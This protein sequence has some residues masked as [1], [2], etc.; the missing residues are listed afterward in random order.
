MFLVV[1]A[2]STLNDPIN[3]ENFKWNHKNTT[4]FLNE[5]R[6][7]IN[8]FKDP[9]IKKKHIWESIANKMKEQGFNVTGGML[10]RKLRNMK[11][12]YRVILDSKHKNP[13][14]GNVHWKYFDVFHEVFQLIEGDLYVPNIVYSD[15]VIIKNVSQDEPMDEEGWETVLCTFPNL[16]QT[17]STSNS[18][19]W[20][21][22]T[23]IV[24]LEKYKARHEQFIDPN[25]KKKDI[26][27]I[28]ASEMRELGYD[29]NW[30]VIDRKF[31]N[32]KVT[33]RNVLE[34]CTK[35]NMGLDRIKWEYFYAF[36]DIFQNESTDDTMNNCVLD[37]VHN[38]LPPIM[39]Q[40]PNNFVWN[41]KSTILFLEEFKKRVDQFSDPIYRKKDIWESITQEMQ[42][43]GYNVNADMLDRKLRNMKVTFRT[44][45]EKD[46]GKKGKKWRYF[47]I[48]QE[49]FQNDRKKIMARRAD[50]TRKLLLIEEMKL[51]E[52][53]KL[54]EAIEESNRISLERIKI[55]KENLMCM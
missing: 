4:T 11:A 12:T 39:E 3:I 22:E 32:M 24:L 46:N 26:W 2:D 6:E 42:S 53:R 23:T 14:K 31:R 48:F 41:H 30:E 40:A 55:L 1:K 17:P 21:H 7:K 16:D 9:K 45:L 37:M 8:D 54:R 10:D 29:V 43:Q 20:N 36:H 5:F 25:N 19:I 51:E 18:F 38:T 49:L 47:N 34:N 27:E 35:K 15:S 50:E 13:E 28:I 44:I 52:L 33:Y